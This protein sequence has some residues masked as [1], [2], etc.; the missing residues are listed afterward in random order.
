MRSGPTASIA[1]LDRGLV[2]KLPGKD[3]ALRDP[4]IGNKVPRVVIGEF[5]DAKT[6]DS[7][8][9][10]FRGTAPPSVD[11]T[12]QK[13]VVVFPLTEQ[14]ELRPMSAPGCGGVAFSYAPFPYDIAYTTTSG[15]VLT[16]EKAY[17]VDFSVSLFSLESIHKTP[18]I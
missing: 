11:F 5:T 1:A 16:C 7:W 9:K 18:V 12:H 17:P 10:S 14:D 3:V 8:S 4:K 13:V 15:F 6:W 2:G